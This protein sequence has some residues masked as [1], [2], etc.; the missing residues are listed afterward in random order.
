M[1]P[2]M[3]ASQ[4]DLAHVPPTGHRT[5]ELRSIAL[6]RLVAE[7]LDDDLRLRARERV[8]GWL[9]VDGPVDHRWARQWQS[10][11]ELPASELRR[12][13]VEDSEEMRDL[14]QST[15]FAGVVSESERRRILQEVR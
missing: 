1:D 12:R 5:A 3:T 10:L 9:A 2:E 13:L 8:A 6:H 4:R 7:R 14:R 15:P 11:L